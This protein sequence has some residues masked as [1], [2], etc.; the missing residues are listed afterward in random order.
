MLA[1]Y[2]A[3]KICRL[4]IPY[5]HI[6]YTWIPAGT[7]VPR[8]PQPCTQN[9]SLLPLSW[10]VR[11][12]RNA[13]GHA[14]KQL[15]SG[16][17]QLCSPVPDCQLFALVLCLAKKPHQTNKTHLGRTESS[18]YSLR[19]ILKSVLVV[20]VFTLHK[21]IAC[22]ICHVKMPSRCRASRDY[23]RSSRLGPHIHGAEEECMFVTVSHHV[24]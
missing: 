16:R 20:R 3:L 24:L 23:S 19:A 10:V 11:R 12:C 2:P 17:C 15:L 7:P 4:L 1:K 6:S 22:F 18:F 5:Y 9:G 8:T 21:S 13:V 14:A